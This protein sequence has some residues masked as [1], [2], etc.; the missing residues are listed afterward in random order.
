M[1][2]LLNNNLIECFAGHAPLFTAF[3]DAVAYVSPIQA[4]CS[5]AGWYAGRWCITAFVYDG[6]TTMHPEPYDRYSEY[7]ATEQEAQSYARYIGL[8]D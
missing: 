2:L 5:G 7:F 6:K 1:A 8:D 3:P 4:M